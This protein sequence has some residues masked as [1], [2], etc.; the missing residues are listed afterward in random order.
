MRYPPRKLIGN[1]TI[2]WRHPADPL[3]TPLGGDP[4]SEAAVVMQFSPL[5]GGEY[6]VL[7]DWNFELNFDPFF[8]NFGSDARADFTVQIIADLQAGLDPAE[9][10]KNSLV[11]DVDVSSLMTG[12][13]RRTQM[14]QDDNGVYWLALQLVGHLLPKEPWVLRIGF[15]YRLIWT[16]GTS[17]SVFNQVTAGVNALTTVGRNVYQALLETEYADGVQTSAASDRSPDCDFELV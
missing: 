5:S 7:V 4:R 2:D 12:L 14:R 17:Q 9:P 15:R 3:V 6:Q 10:D 1:T 11:L 16:H 8:R 13:V